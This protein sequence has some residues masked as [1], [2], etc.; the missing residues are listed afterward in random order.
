GWV[1]ENYRNGREL[2]EGDKVEE[3]EEEMQKKAEIKWLPAMYDELF[4]VTCYYT[5]LESD[6]THSKKNRGKQM[7][8]VLLSKWS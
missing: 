6:F 2:Q 1:L 8:M 3:I 7:E 5:S 4:N